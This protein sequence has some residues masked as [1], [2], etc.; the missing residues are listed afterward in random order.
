MSNNLFSI[1]ELLVY[2]FP[3][4]V[5]HIASAPSI[6]YHFSAAIQRVRDIVIVCFFLLPLTEINT[7][8]IDLHR[9]AMLLNICQQSH[10]ISCFVYS[11]VVNALCT[12][13]SHAIT[14]DLGCRGILMEASLIRVHHHSLSSPTH[15]Y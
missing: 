7:R 1:C 6:S 12:S 13:G 14:L 3:V 11:C 10:Q 8:C 4:S 2:T 5:Y 15:T 9:E